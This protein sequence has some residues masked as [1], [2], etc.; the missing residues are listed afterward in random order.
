[1]ENKFLIPEFSLSVSQTNSMKW[2]G[3]FESELLLD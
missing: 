3:N 2:G 1:M